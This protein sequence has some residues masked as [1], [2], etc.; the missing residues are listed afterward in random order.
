MVGLAAWRVQIVNK[1]K[2]TAATSSNDEGT[3][4]AAALPSIVFSN[5]QITVNYPSSWT[6][7]KSDLQSDSV[8]FDT[9]VR[10]LALLRSGFTGLFYDGKSSFADNSK[11]ITDAASAYK[12]SGDAKPIYVLNSSSRSY[13]YFSW[14]PCEQVGYLIGIG[15]VAASE[16]IIIWFR[17]IDTETFEKGQPSCAPALAAA[18]PRPQVQA[19]TSITDGAYKTLLKEYTKM[20]SN[21]SKPAAHG[22][23][24]TA[25]TQ[26]MS[27]RDAER[28]RDMNT[29]YSQLESYY[30]KQNGYP[31]TVSTTIFSDGQILPAVLID[32]DGHALINHSVVTDAVA[33][34][35][36][37]STV[38]NNYLYVPYGPAGCVKTCTGYI[39]KSY[40]QGSAAWFKNPYT[41]KSIHP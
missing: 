17:R 2:T 15:K 19:I 23:A 41:K 39:L 6:G 9:D 3:S 30:Q 7:I 40:T 21:V 35:A 20:E 27:E 4:I 16:D 11:K 38:A 33:A 26:N 13:T 24:A 1:T 5:E 8:T 28:G 37:N 29:L 32:P 22:T 10:S 14:D 31:S 25:T 36:F 34:A 12:K 18:N